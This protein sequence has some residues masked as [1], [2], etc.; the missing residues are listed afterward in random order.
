MSEGRYF[1][2]VVE[3]CVMNPD[4]EGYRGGRVEVY[5]EQNNSGYAIYEARF[6]IPEEF[7]ETFRE[8]FDC[9]YS[10][11]MPMIKWDYPLTVSKIPDESREG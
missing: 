5:D 4:Y 9:K 10:N 8:M 11:L 6:L 2:S 7:F 3:E 1:F